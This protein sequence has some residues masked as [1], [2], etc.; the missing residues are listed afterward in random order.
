M[1]SSI[2]PNCVVIKASPML[3]R[4]AVGGIVI[5]IL[6]SLPG[7]QFRLHHYF[8]AYVYLLLQVSSL[9]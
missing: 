4:Y 5:G 9:T 2:R 1:K 8:A 3:D 7:L 6:A